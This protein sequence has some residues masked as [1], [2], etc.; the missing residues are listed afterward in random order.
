M[1]MK[2]LLANLLVIAAADSNDKITK[3][4]V[5][6]T[7]LPDCSK[8]SCPSKCECA[9]AKCA[10]QLQDC[11]N[12]YICTRGEDCANLCPCD[13]LACLAVC[14]GIHSSLTTWALYTCASDTCSNTASVVV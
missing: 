3:V 11:L 6:T 5:N 1:A 8:K 2:F 9:E 14:A 7:T 13:D 10:S 4:T 12:D